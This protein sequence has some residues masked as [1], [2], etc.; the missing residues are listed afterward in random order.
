[1]CKLLYAIVLGVVGAAIV[2][3][4]ILFLLPVYTNQ[5]AWAQL[6]K[7]AEL[8]EALLLEQGGEVSRSLGPGNPFLE[9]AACRFDLSRGAVHIHGDGTVPFWSM[10]LYDRTGLN[11]FSFNERTA[12][13]GILDF[14]VLTHGQML[15]MRKDLPAEFRSS[16]FVEVDTS[17]AMFV[18]RSFVPDQTW[19]PQVTSF[20]KGI[21][22]EQQ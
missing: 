9:T 3:I 8:N 20:L 18:V 22:C 6:A 7:S 1:M 19:K 21:T 16:I 5:D 4:V 15:E 2:H 13:D 11:L 12:T 14:V 17:E 10:A